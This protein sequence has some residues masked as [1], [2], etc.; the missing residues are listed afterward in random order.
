MQKEGGRK[1]KGGRKGEGNGRK[2]EGEGRK[3]E[4]RREKRGREKGE[5]DP[6]VPPSVI[7]HL[8]FP[9]KIPVDLKVLNFYWCPESDSK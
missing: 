3:V 2:G 8:K 7:P 1:E 5:R 6:P 4:R 9:Y